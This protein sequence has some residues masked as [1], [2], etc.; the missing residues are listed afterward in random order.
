MPSLEISCGDETFKAPLEWSLLLPVEALQ[1]KA[2]A[3]LLLDLFHLVDDC[4]SR[5][6]IPSQHSEAGKTL[7]S[8]AKLSQNDARFC[9]R[10]L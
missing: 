10:N 3:I 6:G 1:L 9:L 7:S 5:D 4:T 2:D 8:I